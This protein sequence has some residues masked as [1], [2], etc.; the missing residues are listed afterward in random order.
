M[1]ME[2]KMVPVTRY[3]V[4]GKMFDTE[5]DALAYA[6]VREAE[7]EVDAFLEA[8]FPKWKPLPKRRAREAI[9]AWAHRA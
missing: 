4:D 6:S 7:T 2:I 5:E 8:T 9:V 1:S 3:E